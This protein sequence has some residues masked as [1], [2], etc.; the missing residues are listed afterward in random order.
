MRRSPRK[1]RAMTDLGQKMI[2]RADKD[3]LPQDHPIRVTAEGFNA[4]HADGVEAR[5]LL[6]ARASARRVWCEYTGE[7]L[8]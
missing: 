3:G 4:A 8:I 7:P 6:G 1:G 2:D 5:K